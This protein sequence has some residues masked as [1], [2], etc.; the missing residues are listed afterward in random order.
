[1]FVDN[2]DNALI[3]GVILAGSGEKKL[4]AR[5]IGP[6]LTNAGITSP[7]QDPIL[8]LRNSNGALITSNDDWQQSPD[9]QAIVDSGLPPGD[10]RESAL[11]ATLPANG[12]TYTAIVR[13]ARGSSGIGLV[14]LYDLDPPASSARFANISSR[15]NVL[16]GDKA[17]ISGFIISGS[18][19]MGPVKALVRGIGPT[20]PLPGT[21]Q[22]PTLELR[23]S[24]RVIATNDDWKQT[25]QSDIEATGIP[26]VNDRE[27]AVLRWF[28]MGP[29][30]AIL[31]GKDNGT[32]I[33]L[34]EIYDLTN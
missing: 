30:T 1:M 10:A 14:E 15:G 32:G 4:L 24:S 16:G 27:S 11:V 9:K 25:Q 28:P 18:A 6:S 31:R 3:A 8:E 26:P 29:H 2:G 13:P 5:A 34:L 20:I 22:D 21:L 12:S 33:G 17:M 23:D 19:S 7:L